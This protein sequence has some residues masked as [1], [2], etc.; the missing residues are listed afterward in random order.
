MQEHRAMLV[1]CEPIRNSVLSARFSW[2]VECRL[3]SSILSRVA[4]SV[5]GID[6]DREGQR[7]GYQLPVA[8]QNS[9]K[10]GSF[11]REQNFLTSS[12]LQRLLL[13]RMRLLVSLIMPHIGYGGIVFASADAATKRRLNACLRYI[14][15]LRRLDHVSHVETSVMGALLA[16]YYYSRIQFLSFLYKV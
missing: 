8:G 1:S 3:F 11:L 2:N 13:F 12:K 10:I 5:V 14:H 15:S 7:S 4:A 6:N 9:I 16:D